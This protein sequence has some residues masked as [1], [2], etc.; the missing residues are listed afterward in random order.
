MKILIENGHG[1]DT[2]G[3]RSPDGTLREYKYARE[4]AERIVTELKKRGY[5]AERLVPEE[6]DISLRERC[7]RANTICDRLGKEN[8]ILVSVHVNAAGN[9][10]AWMNA[11]GWS[12][13]VS[14]NASANSRALA[15]RLIE[16]A[17]D[18]DL[19]IRRYS[20]QMH[21]WTQDLAICRDTNC[22]AVL[23]ENLFQDNREDVAFLLSEEGREAIARLHVKG[24]VDYLK[25]I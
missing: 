25:G 5:D 9:G 8:V 6:M 13:Y 2:P 15:C 19:K 22:P 23:T 7:R 21:Y 16:A 12:A 24:I 1:S 4:T 17:S 20:P 11:R 14:Q 10:T 18:E 3:K